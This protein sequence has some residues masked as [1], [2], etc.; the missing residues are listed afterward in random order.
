MNIKQSIRMNT[1]LN[2]GIALLIVGA[3]PSPARAQSVLQKY[4]KIRVLKPRTI[5][6]SNPGNPLDSVLEGSPSSANTRAYPPRIHEDL[7]ATL[8]V[9]F[10]AEYKA[11]TRQTF[12]AAASQLKSAVANPKWTA[13]PP[14]YASQPNRFG[15]TARRACVIMDVDETVLDNS[16]YQ[17]ELILTDSAFSV[18][19]WN[20]FVNRRTSPAVPGAKLF[21][22]A[23]R[24]QNV[25]VFFVTNRAASLETATRD[26]LIAQGLMQPADPDLIFC[27]NERAEWTSGKSVR[28]D[29]IASRYRVLL[30]LGDDLNDFL[31]VQDNSLEQRSNLANRYQQYWGRRWFM[32]PNPNYG[33]WETATIAG[34]ANS[35][36]AATRQQKM[37]R[38]GR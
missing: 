2:V 20:T 35:S 37:K 13:I 28:R 18:D 22:D 33:S 3:F 9:R 21:I 34:N 36:P 38:L 31:P 5:E 8:W 1:I 6:T 10:A 23:C 25:Q 17:R 4:L 24:R 26:N 12:L 32:L 27:K 30:I 7:D 29:W 15:N 11:L 19:T 16:A 14:A